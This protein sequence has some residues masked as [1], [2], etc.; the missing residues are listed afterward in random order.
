MFR[1]DLSDQPQLFAF[2]PRDLVPDDSD[3]WL[4]VDLFNALDLSAFRRDYAPRGE[5]ALDPVLMLRTLFYG[6]THGVVTGRKLEDACRFD[7]RFVVLS[8][9]QQ[10]CYRSFSRFIERHRT[11][12]A[13][14][15]AQVVRLAQ[16]MGLVTLGRVAI[17]GTR[18]KANTSRSKAMSHERMLQA[19]KELERQ[20]EA[21]RQDLASENAK[22]QT[23]SRLPDEIKRREERLAKIKAA[24]AAIEREADGGRVEPKAQK[25]FADHDAKAMAK[26]K[27]GFM[28]GYNCQAAVDEASQIIVAAELHDQVPDCR[29]LPLMLDRAAEVCGHAGAEVLADKGY[30]SSSNLAAIDAAGA[31]AFIAVGR[32]EAAGGRAPAEDL[33]IHRLKDGRVQYRCRHGRPFDWAWQRANERVTLKM[34][35]EHCR[36]CGLRGRCLLHSRNPKQF[37]VPGPKSARLWANLHK[38]MRTDEGRVTYSRRKVIVEPVFANIKNK[39]MMIQVRGA[40]KVGAWWKMA[41]TAHNIEKIVR[42]AASRTG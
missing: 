30:L 12:F 26:P 11:R 40:A 6:L 18:M 15:F 23:S 16:A 27:D 2:T 3:V 14:L 22:E 38:R 35:A 29:A 31:K 28:Y 17:D 32:G 24:Q 41:A 4:Y 9:Q 36:G 20:L 8:G 34:G 39:G 19:T 7:N 10:P 25:S 1:T 5:Q 21:L 37:E 42:A 13:P 33:R